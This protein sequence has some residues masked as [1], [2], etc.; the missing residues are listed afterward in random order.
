MKSIPDH[1]LKN[2]VFKFLLRSFCVNCPCTYQWLL[3]LNKWLLCRTCN[4][5]KTCAEC[6]IQVL[7]MLNRIKVGCFDIC[8]VVFVLFLLFFK[9]HWGHIPQ[10]THTHIHTYLISIKP[11]L[12]CFSFFMVHIQKPRIS[13]FTAHTFKNHIFLNLQQ[14]FC[15]HLTTELSR[16]W[17]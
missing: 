10:R 8:F 7:M 2:D 9:N 4:K 12:S 3:V 6:I 14:T 17:N 16:N 13:E 15:E 5:Y 1:G 11:L